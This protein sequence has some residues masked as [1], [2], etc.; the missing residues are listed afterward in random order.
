[1]WL[2]EVPPDP[3]KRNSYVANAWLIA[4]LPSLA[5]FAARLA[6]GNASLAIPLRPG[7]AAFAAYSILLAPLLET[8]AMLPIAALL[9]RLPARSNVLRI[10][11]LAT[12]AA[13]AHAIQ[14]GLWAALGAFWPFVVYA[15]CIF[16]WWPRGLR[17]AFLITAAV[18]AL[19]NA[20]FLAIGLGAGWLASGSAI[21]S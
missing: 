20:S 18:H 17:D 5:L 13:A 7:V 1:M 14:G 19:Y 21:P 10:L 11:I 3:A 2:L 12:L 8:A 4:L 6:A 9:R 16:A 15:A